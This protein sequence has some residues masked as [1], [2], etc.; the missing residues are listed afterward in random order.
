M[1]RSFAAISLAA[2]FAATGLCQPSASKPGFEIADVHVSARD[3]WVKSVPNKMR[4]GILSNGRYEIRRATMLDLIQTAYSVDADQVFGG[5]S[6]LDY[7]RFDIAAKAPQTTTQADLR[8]M[9]QSLL[10]ERFH[11]VVRPDSKPLPAWLISVA[12][13]GPKLKHADGSDTPECQ[14]LPPT[15]SNLAI[16]GIR[17]RNAA[18]D[19]FLAT[20][21]SYSGRYF[22]NLPV[23]DVTGL[24]GDWDID[25]QYSTKDIAESLAKQLGLTVELKTA[26]Q[27]VLSVESVMEQ[28]TAN[29]PGVAAAL[30]PLPAPAFDVASVKLCDPAG[31]QTQLRF[32]P[33]GRVTGECVFLVNL[34]KQMWD[35]APLQ[36]L[37]GLPG[38]ELKISIDA[39]APP[40]TY[41]DPTGAEDRDA[42]K[43]MVRALLI[44]RFKMKIRYEDRAVDAATLVALKPKLT[45]AD[46]A[47]RTGCT[48]Q[49]LPDG[50]LRLICRNMTMAQF[51]EQIPPFDPFTVFFPVL[52]ATGIEGAWDFTFSFSAPPFFPPILAGARGADPGQASE[53]SGRLVFADAL[54]KQL[55]LKLEMRKRP[56]YVLVI[57]HMEQNPTE[58]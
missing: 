42:L 46:P 48:R 39:K 9:L 45:R 16:L 36:D 4:P 19:R 30:P 23:M 29:S 17:C 37:P 2:I 18:M 52:D 13:G 57:D 21:R 38:G 34:V 50:P 49:P 53:P 56:E 3:A 24:E 8:L 43:A 5:P 32:L 33:G 35:L 22:R 51:A 26:P 44:D 11:L 28:T 58:N 14:N 25:V 47:T 6:W 7:D 27:P 15:I 1:R 54:A 31:R 12:K 55:G 20:L 10:A 40:G 41:I